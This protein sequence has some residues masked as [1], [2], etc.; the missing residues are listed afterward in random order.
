MLDTLS[1]VAMAQGLSLRAQRAI[2]LELM[3][4]AMQRRVPE[5]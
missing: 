4:E 1:D 3:R 5:A 2:D